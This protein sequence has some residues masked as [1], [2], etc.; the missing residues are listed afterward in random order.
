MR[1]LSILL[2]LSLAQAAHAADVKTPAEIYGELFERVQLE[3]VYPDSKSFVDALPVSA[4][5]QVLAEYRAGAR[6]TGFRSAQVRRRA[7]HAAA[8]GGCRVSHRA[9]PGRARAHRCAVEGAGA[10]ARGSASVLVA[11]GA[12]A[13][14][15][16]A[17][18]A[19]QRDLLLGLVL[20]DARAGGK[21]PA[22]P[23]GLDAR[24][25][26][27]AHRPVR[28]RA[29]RQSQLLPQPLAAAVLRG[30]GGAGRAA[31]RRRDL[32][33]VPAAAAPR[34]RS[35]GWRAK[36]R[37][38]PA[39]RIVAWCACAT[40]RC[41]IATG[42]IATRRARKPIAR[43]SRRRATSGRPAAEVYRNLRAAAESGW[44][45]GSRWL[46]DGKT[47][48]TI[49]TTDFI[50]PD[51]NSLLYQL[52]LT[53]AKACEVTADAA[54]AK[55]MR[56]RAADA[57]GGR[58]ANPVE[59]RGR[60]IHGLRLA[61][62]EEQRP[63]FARDAVS[64]L[65]QAERPGARRARSPRRSARNCCNRTASRRRRRIPASSGMRRTAGRRCSGSPS[66]A[67]ATTARKRSRARSRSAGSRRICRSIAAPASWSKNTT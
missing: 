20:H 38:R 1:M 10:Q 12:A 56:T 59:L 13:S 2:L 7:L 45:F 22:R 6:P 4:P 27:V 21:R 26:R 16:G 64:A 39:R 60:R 37:S 35:S 9:R 34:V 11:P 25:L 19:L 57:Q 41:S 54:C 47:L 43:T 31:R 18:W 50:P 66:A 28:P 29:E 14:L 48:G 61:R 58:R 17:G 23:D 52:E 44:D 3:H 24:Q 36:T 5:E 62:A 55:D 53:I 51:L 15:R 63:R 40:A 46:A 33:Q 32:S 30:D 8:C 65:L 42:T 49:H 67:C